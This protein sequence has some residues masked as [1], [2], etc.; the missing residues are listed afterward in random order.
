M[1]K[2]DILVTVFNVRGDYRE[3]EFNSS[4]EFIE[5]FLFP[6]E[7]PSVSKVEILITNSDDKKDSHITLTFLNDDNEIVDIT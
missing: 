6:D 2:S 1:T 5:K 3:I 4:K 7:N